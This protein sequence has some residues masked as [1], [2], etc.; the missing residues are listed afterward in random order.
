MLDRLRASIRP[1]DRVFGCLS[2]CQGIQLLSLWY[3]LTGMIAILSLFTTPEAKDEKHTY[4]ELTQLLRMGQQTFNIFA[5]WAGSKGY[6]GSTLKIIS[7]IQILLA[8][9]VFYAIFSAVRVARVSVIC[10]EIPETKCHD[11][12]T[13]VLLSSATDFIWNCYFAYIA[14]SY[15]KKLEDGSDLPRFIF[16]EAFMNTGAMPLQYDMSGGSGNNRGV[17]GEMPTDGG[18]RLEEGEAV[19]PNPTSG[20]PQPFSGTA[21]RLE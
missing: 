1:A 9:I 20:A 8:Y 12:Q 19:A 15:V 11:L 10:D 7:H 3:M 21:Y 18:R 13:L 17:T 2:V 5:F 6:M 16:D 4:S 14:W